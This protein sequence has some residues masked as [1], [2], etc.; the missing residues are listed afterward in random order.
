MND[1]YNNNNIYNVLTM[2]SE[3]DQEKKN[4]WEWNQ[5]PSG[6]LFSCFPFFF[7]GGGEVE[8]PLTHIRHG[9]RY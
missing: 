1:N 4:Q 2:H 8:Y 7:L 5:K 6:K 9:I 3:N